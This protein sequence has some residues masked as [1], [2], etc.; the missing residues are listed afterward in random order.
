[1]IS[2]IWAQSKNNIIGKDNKL[3]WNIKEEMQ[4]FINYTKNKTILM[5][6]NTWDSL[7][8]KPLPNRKN[9][10][11]TSRE[12]EKSYNNLEVSNNLEEIL[13]KYQL[14]QEELVII[15][16]SQIYKS[17]LNYADKLV[18]SI[19]KQNYPGDVFAPQWDNLLFKMTHKED[20]SEFTTY[21]YERQ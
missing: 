21:Y 5:G 15:G 16:G 1:M 2:L 4:H 8:K 14:S 18:I 3:P 13:K 6:R 17:A 10:L 19:I 9:I 12:L 7:S 11:I 20:F